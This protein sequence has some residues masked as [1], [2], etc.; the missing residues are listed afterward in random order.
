MSLTVTFQ[1]EL[2]ERMPPTAH[3]L[4]PVL[5]LPVLQ[6]LVTHPEGSRLYADWFTS[7][8]ER[9][10][11]S[12]EDPYNYGFELDH[13]KRCDELL[14]L[15]GVD[16]LLILGGNRAG[17]SEYAAKRAVDIAVRKP[18]AIIWCL[19]TTAASSIEMQQPLVWKYLPV[20]WKNA[21]KNQVTNVSFTKKNGF[22]DGKLVGPNGSIIVFKNYAQ[23]PDVIEGG[24]CDYIWADELVPVDWV[25]TLRYRI[26]TRRGRLIVTF[27]PIHGYTPTV[28]E[29]VDGA[30]TVEWRFAERLKDSVN[31]PGGQQ[32]FMPFIQEP[33]MFSKA[34]I[35]YFHSI[36]NPF[37]GYDGIIKT[38]EKESDS[39]IKQRLYGFADK[40]F[41]VAFPNF[42]E[43]NIVRP[44]NLPAT[45][46]NYCVIDPAGAR[47]WFILWWRV[48]PGNPPKHYIYREWPT[49]SLGPW[50]EPSN[51]AQVKDG[52]IGPGQQTLGYGIEEYKRLM[53]KLEKCG[54]TEID[55]HRRSVYDKRGLKEPREVIMDRLVDPRA[56]RNQHA[57]EK[58]GTCL[59]DR[60]A[61][62]TTNSYGQ[63][64]SPVMIVRPASGVHIDDGIGE[65]NTLLQWNPERTFMPVLNEPRLYVSAECKNTIW[66][67]STW[68]GLDG[69]KGACK[70]PIDCLRYGALADFHYYAPGVL[71]SRGGGS[72]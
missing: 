25:R 34:R 1:H 59:L 63:T 18:N 6:K 30:K 66:A 64:T 5:E 2:Y 28:K 3:P 24:E 23:K 15:P 39:I 45:G 60:M 20:E 42:G 54:P 68:T 7:R 38:L 53:L 14:E 48:A 52:V 31:A 33:T 13:W 16:E 55:P 4:V 58:G 47:N 41:N 62:A 67:L 17:K 65:L 37:G 40:G 32:G 71:G 29:Y 50:A 70:D 9:I 61:T 11:L 69:E 35:V 10:R 21:P 8:E 19:H 36:L 57:A 72:Y 44:E 22:A 43:F 49:V 51:D 12:G 27:T 26:V 56:G 46:T